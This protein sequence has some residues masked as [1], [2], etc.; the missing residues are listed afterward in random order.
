MRVPTLIVHIGTAKTGSTA[1]Q[2]ALH[3]QRGELRSHGVA[4]VH[5]PGFV[6]LREVAAA[7]VD[8]DGDDDHLDTLGLHD[9]DARRAF[10]TEVVDRFRRQ[11]SSAMEDERERVETVVVSS[12]HFHSRLV[13]P[14]AVARLADVVRPLAD[15]VRVVCYLRRQVDLFASFYSTHLRNG[16]CETLDQVGDRLSRL[17]HPYADYDH[18]LSMW[19]DAFG[20]DAIE[21]RLFGRDELVGGT[22][23]ADVA[24]VIGLPDGVLVEEPGV[25]PSISRLG[26]VLMLAINRAVAAGADPG[27]LAEARGVVEAACTGP[28]ERWPPDEAAARQAVFD[29][30]N[31]AVRR[32]WFPDRAALFPTSFAP[33]PAIDVDDEARAVLT[34]LFRRLTEGSPAEP[35]PSTPPVRRRRRWR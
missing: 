19:A 10:R 18:L 14:T 3:R 24:R 17:G 6:N 13:T 16:G 26:Q 1:I 35:A 29:P 23:V 7:C 20:A 33:P 21:P 27:P 12:E 32:R 5:D 31:E 8:D 2:V 4:Y 15:R 28:G 22:I 9:V 11:V 25:N 34:E 30:G